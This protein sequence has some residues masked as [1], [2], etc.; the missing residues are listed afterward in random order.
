MKKI[1]L[2]IALLSSSFFMMATVHTVEVGGSIS[3]T[4]YYAPQNLMINQGDTVV[5]D[6]VLGTHNCTTTSGPESFASGDIESP[7]TFQYVFNEP[8]TYDYE[9]TLFSHADTQF[10]TIEV[11]GVNSVLESN[12]NEFNVYPNP[13]SDEAF[14]EIPAGTNVLSSKIID[15]LGREIKGVIYKHQ[16]IY[17]SDLKS[18]QYTIIVETE[19]GTLQRRVVV[20]K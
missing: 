20:K 1:L 5:W 10:G 7:G 9:C 2:S 14:I 4:P 16:T 19:S 8:G 15:N 18:G 3:V 11:S 12:S 13:I 6:F 17:A